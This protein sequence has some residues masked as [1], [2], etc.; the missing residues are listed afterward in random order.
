MGAP[1]FFEI[2]G[3]GAQN[4]RE[5]AVR[6]AQRIQQEVDGRFPASQGYAQQ[7]KWSNDDAHKTV[8]GGGKKVHQ[9]S[10]YNTYAAT[11]DFARPPRWGLRVELEVSERLIRID[12]RDAMPLMN[13]LRSWS[14]L[15]ALVGAVGIGGAWIG[16]QGK[17]LEA[18]GSLIFIIPIGT[19]LLWPLCRLLVRFPQYLMSRELRAAAAWL[20]SRSPA[21]AVDLEREFRIGIIPLRY[22]PKGTWLVLSILAGLAATGI[23]IWAA[24]QPQ[25]KMLWGAFAAVAAGVAALGCLGTHQHFKSPPISGRD[26]KNQQDWR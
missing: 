13:R 17:A 25:E 3:L 20:E 9:Q 6:F 23:G 19:L 21:M 5:I 12:A 18:A 16:S 1:A 14:I 10:P 22:R 4:A 7:L 15:A 26:P 11:L 8:Y 2:R 24:F